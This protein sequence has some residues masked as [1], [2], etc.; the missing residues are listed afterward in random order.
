VRNEPNGVADAFKAF[1]AAGWEQRAATYALFAAR[2]T[3]RLTDRLLDAAAVGPGTRVLDIGS[4]PGHLAARAAERDARVVAI[5]LAE[6]M[7]EEARSRHAGIEFRLGDAE[8]LPFADASFDATVAA[9]VLLHLAHPEQAVAEAVRVLAPGG[10]AAFTVWDEPVRCRF[11]GV[12]IDAVADA[13][14]T[15]PADLPAG[16][17]LFRFA[18]DAEF[19]S[20]L[21]EA[22]LANVSVEAVAFEEP[23]ES[24]DELWNGL[25]CGTVRMSP[26]ILGQTK[27]M[28][29]RIRH[30]FEQLLE[31]HR[32]GDGFAVPVAAKL[33]SGSKAA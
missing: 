26:L 24:A 33:A 27:A 23:I 21:S 13:G 3:S 7:L 15:P 2:I 19:A 28:Q 32:S 4:G 18:S 10:R 17:P 5:D 6:A 30:S 11:L 31:E 8:A 20:L 25:M 1:E 9:F 16:P 14:A 12:L 22:G 29:R